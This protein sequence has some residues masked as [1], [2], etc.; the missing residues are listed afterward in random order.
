MTTTTTLYKEDI[1]RLVRMAYRQGREDVLV[2]IVSDALTSAENQISGLRNTLKKLEEKINT[3][4]WI[5]S[6]MFGPH[7]D[8]CK[9]CGRLEDY[10]HKHGHD[11][12]CLINLVAK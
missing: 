4:I 2:G 11:P 1:L 9:Y 7:E 12:E 6:P 3:N 5:P 10:V 8:E